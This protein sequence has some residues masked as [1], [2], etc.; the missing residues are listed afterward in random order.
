MER[1]KR[2]KSGSIIHSIYIMSI[3]LKRYVT[4]TYML[5]LILIEKLCADL[6]VQE[7]YAS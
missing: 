1:F 5:K 3:G 7:A 4:V 6:Q 2:V